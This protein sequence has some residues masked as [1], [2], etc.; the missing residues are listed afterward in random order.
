MSSSFSS[1]QEMKNNRPEKIKVEK[2][3]SKMVNLKNPE[4]ASYQLENSNK[5]ELE[6]ISSV[7]TPNPSYHFGSEEM[8]VRLSA[9]FSQ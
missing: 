4:P 7:I 3:S 2:K 1:T 8:L 6:E 5:T 9:S